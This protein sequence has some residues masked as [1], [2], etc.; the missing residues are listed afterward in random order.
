MK[1][2]NRTILAIATLMSAVLGSTGCVAGD[3]QKP[4]HAS[5][6]SNR[7]EVTEQQTTQHRYESER[8]DHVFG[9]DDRR[10][11]IDYF[12]RQPMQA[13]P[14]PPGIAKNY[15]RGKPLPPGIAKRYLP[16]EL[17]H[18]LPARPGY[19]YAIVGRDVVLIE[20]AT[21]LVVDMLVDVL[22]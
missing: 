18:M 16:G 3:Q 1:A 9:D 17:N 4:A 14:L 7:Y 11:I 5:D 8:H 2:L 22:N 21:H 19:E 13:Q 12:H 6:K 15:A 20:L 10:I